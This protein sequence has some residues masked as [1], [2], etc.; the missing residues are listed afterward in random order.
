MVDVDDPYVDGVIVFNVK[1][2][3]VGV[4]HR[5]VD[6]VIDNGSDLIFGID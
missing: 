5:V 1:D 4:G 2:S 6:V 3:G